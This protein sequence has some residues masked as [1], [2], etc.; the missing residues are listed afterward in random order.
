MPISPRE[1]NKWRGKNYGTVGGF[2]LYGL[3]RE[4]LYFQAEGAKE[5][6]ILGSNA[7]TGRIVF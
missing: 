6:K 2:L 5:I 4:N 3:S 1:V 7:I